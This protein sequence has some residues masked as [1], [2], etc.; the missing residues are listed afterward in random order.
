M[1]DEKDC[2]GL[3]PTCDDVISE[4]H[5]ER[6]YPGLEILHSGPTQKAGGDCVVCPAEVPSPTHPSQLGPCV[7]CT[8]CGTVCTW[9][10][11]YNQQV[12]LVFAQVTRWPGSSSWVPSV[13]CSGIGQDVLRKKCFFQF[14]VLGP[15]GKVSARGFRIQ[16]ASSRVRVKVLRRNC[17]ES[18]Y[19]WENYLGGNPVEGIPHS[20]CSFPPGLT[21]GLSSPV[22]D[23]ASLTLTVGPSDHCQGVGSSPGLFDPMRYC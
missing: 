22:P 16:H 23:H 3:V 19:G 20:S 7:Q 13:A 17:P 18:H 12:L 10:V 1:Q 14:F 9:Q 5:K 4:D 6:L 11:S 2:G 15:I 8:G 21:L